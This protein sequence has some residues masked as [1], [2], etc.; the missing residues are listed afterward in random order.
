[1]NYQTRSSDC[2]S[3]YIR[4]SV[5]DEIVLRNLR[6]VTEFAR[7]RAEEF[8]AMATTNGEAEAEKF[9][10]VA[11]REKQ[12]LEKRIKELD[13]IIRCLYE[14]RV[15]EIITPERYD[16]MASG[17][18]QE[19]T[20]LKEKLIAV[21]DGISRMDMRDSCIREFIAKAKQYIEMPTLTPELLRVFIRKIEVFEK[22]EKYSRIAGNLINIHYAFQLPEQDGMPVLEMLLPSNMRESA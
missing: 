10:K 2:T 9:Y 4:E 16:T 8:Y 6:Q 7:E 19:Q 17:Y 11:E 18:E 20:A 14:D 13:N 15:C 21:N 12:Q 22:L 1:M 5:L 3:H